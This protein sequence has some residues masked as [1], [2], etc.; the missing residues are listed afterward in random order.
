M[1]I[2]DRRKRFRSEIK[3]LAG[4]MK[5]KNLS[6]KEIIKNKGLKKKSHNF[7]NSEDFFSLAKTG[8]SDIERLL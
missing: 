3:R 2:H 1:D 4:E 6:L 8:D 5:E 7:Y